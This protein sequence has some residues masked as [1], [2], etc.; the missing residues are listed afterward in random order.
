MEFGC[1]SGRTDKLKLMSLSLSGR[2]TSFSGRRASWD[3]A[4]VS[5]QR[6]DLSARLGESL[7]ACPSALVTQQPDLR[8]V[9]EG[10]P[11]FDEDGGQERFRARSPDALAVLCR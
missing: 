9:T 7:R 8:V 6:P 3:E 11:R 4:S 10:V 5:C 2:L 1:G